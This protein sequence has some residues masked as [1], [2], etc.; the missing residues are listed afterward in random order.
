MS[1]FHTDAENSLNGGAGTSPYPLLS[2][3]EGSEEMVSC[4]SPIIGG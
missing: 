4:G 2:E 1:L 3:G